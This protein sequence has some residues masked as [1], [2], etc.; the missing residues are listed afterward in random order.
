MP[1]VTPRRRGGAR[2]P[3]AAKLALVLVVLFA[4]VAVSGEKKCRGW[5]GERGIGKSPTRPKQTT[6]NKH[7]RRGAKKEAPTAA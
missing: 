4:V 7:N 3:A 6:A 2:P 5:W 1:S